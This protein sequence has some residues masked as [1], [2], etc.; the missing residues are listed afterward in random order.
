MHKNSDTAYGEPFSFCENNAHGKSRQ[1]RA[2]DPESKGTQKTF[3]V[4]A[5][6]DTP[7]EAEHFRHGRILQ[8]VLHQLCDTRKN[9]PTLVLAQIA[10]LTAALRRTSR[11]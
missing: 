11:R 6:I 5:R 10:I 9:C 8:D 3:T 4:T 1:V 7:D 2:A